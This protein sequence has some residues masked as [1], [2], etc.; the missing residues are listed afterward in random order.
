[1]R[2]EEEEEEEEGREGKQVV[3]GRDLG[4]ETETRWK[5]LKH[6]HTQTHILGCDSGL[7][8]S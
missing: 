8:G 3:V 2:K 7:L 5:V 6:S 1:M 4:L